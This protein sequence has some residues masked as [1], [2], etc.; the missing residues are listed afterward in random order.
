MCL[1]TSVAL[2]VSSMVMMSKVQRL[3]EKLATTLVEA[4]AVRPPFSAFLSCVA[5][6]WQRIVTKLKH[7]FLTLYVRLKPTFGVY[8]YVPNVRS[9]CIVRLKRTFGVQTYVLYIYVIGVRMR[10]T[11]H[12][13]LITWLNL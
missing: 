8:T 5:T 11:T 6:V 13:R 12:A 10:I 7:K 2:A 9:E 1:S 4:A 3:R